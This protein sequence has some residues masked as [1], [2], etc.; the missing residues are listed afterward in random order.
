VLVAPTVVY[1]LFNFAPLSVEEFTAA[2]GIIAHLRIPHHAEPERWFDGIALGQVAWVVV[3]AVLVRK[4]PLFWIMLIPFVLSLLLTAAQ[5]LT[6]NDTLALLFPWRISVILVP[7]STAVMVAWLVNDLAPWFARRTSSQ[8]MAVG[9]GCTVVLALLMAGGVAIWVFEL[10]YPSNPDELPVLEFIRAHKTAGDQY[11][12]PVS[13]PKLKGGPRGAAS[14]NFTPAPRAGKSGH[15]IAID[16]QRFRLVTGAP[17]F[18]D[19]K[20]IPYKDVE[21]LEWKRRLLWAK[22]IYSG[23]WNRKGLKEDLAREGITHVIATTDLDSK[24]LEK[25]YPNAEFADPHYR[26]YRVAKD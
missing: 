6:G 9:I 8:R 21:V 2:Q 22:E 26:I 17:L 12:L 19:F 10:G 1:N 3:A 11:L 15:L 24:I 13:L 5:V 14:T 20:S 18:V 25:I 7:L 4:T 16:M 23:D